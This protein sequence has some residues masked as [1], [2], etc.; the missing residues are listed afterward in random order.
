MKPICNLCSLLY[1]EWVVGPSDGFPCN[2]VNEVANEVKEQL[3]DLKEVAEG[4]A[5]PEGEATSQR[6]EQAAILDSVVNLVLY[7]VFIQS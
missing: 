1:S 6:V 5:K 7:C 3:E 2:P 4:D